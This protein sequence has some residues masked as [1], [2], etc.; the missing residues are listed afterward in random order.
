MT[1]LSAI[2]TRSELA[3]AAVVDDPSAAARDKLTLEQVCSR[4]HSSA[5]DVPELLDMIHRLQRELIQMDL[6]N[7]DKQ[8]DLDAAREAW[9]KAERDVDAIARSSAMI[10]ATWLKTDE[11]MMVLVNHQRAGIMGCGCGWAELGR[12]HPKHVLEKL[13]EVFER[14]IADG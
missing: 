6:W 5:Q 3:A 11:A 8:R 1:D 7:L 2:R 13:A 4:W 12:S 14:G 10:F 9:H